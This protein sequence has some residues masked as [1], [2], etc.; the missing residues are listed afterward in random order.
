MCALTDAITNNTNVVNNFISNDDCC[1]REQ[2]STNNNAPI[3]FASSGLNGSGSFAMVLMMT[4]N[5]GPET[6]NGNSGSSADWTDS[7]ALDYLMANPDLLTHYLQNAETFIDQGIDP[8]EFARDHYERW[9]SDEGRP[10]VGGSDLA[11]NDPSLGGQSHGCDWLSDCLA[12]LGN[13][14]ESNGW[15]AVSGWLSAI[16]GQYSPSASSNT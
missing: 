16:M 8:A 11:L 9:G 4:G 6:G 2:A 5:G 10:T 7:E 1:S 12:N 15:F 13:L 3:S 14:S